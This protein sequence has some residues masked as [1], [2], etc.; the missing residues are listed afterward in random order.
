MRCPVCHDP[1]PVEERETRRRV[2]CPACG[3]DSS[4]RDYKAADELPRPRGM[5]ADEWAWR[6]AL[7]TL[8]RF[9]PASH[10]LEALPVFADWL[11]DNGRPE[12]AAA[13]ADWMVYGAKRADPAKWWQWT[14]PVA[15]GWVGIETEVVRRSVFDLGA[16]DWVHGFVPQ[17][18]IRTP[19]W[20]P[21]GA[22][23]HNGTW[24]LGWPP[25]AVRFTAPLNHDPT[26]YR[27]T[28]GINRP[29]R[30]AESF[31]SHGYATLFHPPGALRDLV[32]A[33]ADP[34]PTLFDEV[35]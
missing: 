22:T 10:L 4:R 34:G 28:I 5:G 29:R 27:V 23:L 30:R 16:N 2:L 19:K 9:E 6:Q 26:R 25:G 14:V 11:A 31:H 33:G 17:R 32:P 7:Y 15:D 8:W 12:E 21:L 35:T 20:V 24:F 1:K 13:R 3:Y 18:F